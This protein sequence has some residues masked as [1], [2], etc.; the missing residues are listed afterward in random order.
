MTKLEIRANVK[1][2]NGTECLNTASWGYLLSC[3]P[4]LALCMT[5]ILCSN[6]HSCLET[7]PARYMWFKTILHS[8][9]WLEACVISYDILACIFWKRA[10]WALNKCLSRIIIDE[11]RQYKKWKWGALL[12]G[13]QWAQ[14]VQSQGREREWVLERWDPRLWEQRAF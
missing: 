1:A 7:V 5:D 9:T 2:Y 13:E 8:E 3:L 6:F 4:R 10:Q 11:E 12:W 14:G